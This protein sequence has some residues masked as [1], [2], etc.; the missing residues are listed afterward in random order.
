MGV[1]DKVR[2]SLK[3]KHPDLRY[4]D[5]NGT[6]VVHAPSPGGFDVSISEGLVVGFDGWHEHFDAEEKALRCFAFGFSGQCRLKVTLRGQFAHKWTL[7]TLENGQWVED[8]T[9]GLLLFPFWRPSRVEY[10]QNGI[11]KKS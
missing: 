10:R 6:I 1:L 3:T 8:S 5:A 2:H 9:T 11:L 7:E 4:T